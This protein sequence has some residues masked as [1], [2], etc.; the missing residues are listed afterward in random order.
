MWQMLIALYF[1][2]GT[3]SY[4]L[5]KR[6]AD[7]LSEHNRLINTVFFVCFLLPAA[8]LLSLLFP[9]NLNVGITNLLFLLVGS[10]IWPLFYIA[11]FRANKEV[12][13]S[14]F[15]II[16]NVSPV[17]TLI[18]AYPFLRERI[19]LLQLL[20]I[21]LLIFSGMLA[22][23][24]Q[25]KTHVKVSRKGL[26]T[27]LVSAIILGIA[28]AYE[29][30]MLTRVDIGAY[31]IYGWGAQIAWSVLLTAKELKNWP[32]LFRKEQIRKIVLIWGAASALR[33]VSFIL[34]LKLSS[35]SLISAS[36]DFLSVMIILAAYLYL[37]ERRHM[38]SKWTAAFVGIIGLLLTTS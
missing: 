1:L 24:S 6:L 33:S 34:A 15:T 26:L 10:L 22:A 25:L 23:I 9:H 28:V 21:V 5:R 19:T 38:I 35:A 2:F 32:K 36:S 7:Q 27:C 18:V 29:R 12:D 3:I 4:I 30:F 8:I 16:S 37:N 14:I 17:F 13:V 11:S 20:G 31:L